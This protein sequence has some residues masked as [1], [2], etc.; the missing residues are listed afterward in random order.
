MPFNASSALRHS[1]AR[2]SGLVEYLA[3]AYTLLVAY[4]SLYPFHPWRPLASS[5]LAFLFDAWPRYYTQADVA[6]NVLGYLP[7][8]LL[9]TL[10][11]MA[12]MTPRWAA[13]IAVI[14]GTSVSLGM[15][16]L[17]S[18]LPPRVPSNLDLLSNGLGALAGA[19]VAV[20]AGERWF[21]SGQLYR[22]RHRMFLPGAAVDAGFV[23][24]VLWL[25]T[26]LYPA[27]WLF[28]NGDLRFLFEDLLNLTYSPGSYRWIEAGVT[29]LNLAGIAVL[30]S[31]LAR[32][33]QSVAAPLLLLVTVALLLKSATAVILFK[34]GDAALW[35]TPGSLLGIPA[36]VALY[37]GLMWL[38]R[39]ILPVV[40]AVLVLAGAVLVNIAP[41]NPYILASIQIWSHGHFLSFNGTTRLVSTVWPFLAASYLVWWSRHGTAD[42][43]RPLRGSYPS[44]G[45]R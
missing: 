1:F 16:T 21:L 44:Q 3:V 11:A 7:L 30:T 4:A 20:A 25:F 18:F 27:V 29:T 2:R 23:V 36:G 28:G 38:A 17:Q 6:L 5:P 14:A 13:L 15:E 8:G 39:P 45:S 31:V 32:A 43:P 22:W 37:L 42:G 26:Q 9:V 40:A 10:A 33:R 24:L 35:L 34:P 12:W 41:R 19:I